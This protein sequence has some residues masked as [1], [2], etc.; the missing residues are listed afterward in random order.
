LGAGAAATT[1]R[2]IAPNTPNIVEL[3]DQSFHSPLNIKIQ[4]DRSL[5]VPATIGGRR[6]SSSPRC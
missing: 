4:H 2:Y 3:S 6:D 5:D 1:Q